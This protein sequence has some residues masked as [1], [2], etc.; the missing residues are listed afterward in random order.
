MPKPLEVIRPA[1]LRRRKIPTAPSGFRGTRTEFIARHLEPMLPDVSV[2]EGFHRAFVAYLRR[3]DPV[4]LV[5]KVGNMERRVAVST[6]DG[7]VVK[8]TDNAPAWWWYAV[9]FNAVPVDAEQMP[10][11][12]RTTPCH[13]HDVRGPTVNR[14]GWYVAHVLNARNGDTKW[15]NWSRSAV[16]WRFIRNIHPCNVFYVPRIDRIEGKRIGEDAGLIES[17]AAHYRRRYAAIWEEFMQLAGAPMGLGE[18]ASDGPLVINS[19][20][21]PPA[22]ISPPRRGVTRRTAGATAS[23]SAGAWRGILCVDH[24]PPVGKFL[25]RHPDAIAFTQQLLSELT[26]ERIIAIAD[27]LH[28]KCRVRELEAAAPGDPRRQAELAWAALSLGS[29]KIHERPSGWTG[30][31]KLLAV[32]NVEGL[33][34]VA[35]LDIGAVAGVCARIVSGP[36]RQAN[37]DG[38]R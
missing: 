19:A 34:A 30:C 10:A 6:R 16:V 12:I 31:A 5:R 2:V 17:V 36:Y 26:V 11:F 13:M 37:A 7:T 8:P 1:A 25:A 21:P 33:A 9:L 35:A 27:A 23:M 28:N 3:P 32:G 29:R 15:Q 18:A 20:T 14:A 4:F 38:L 24:A 22:A